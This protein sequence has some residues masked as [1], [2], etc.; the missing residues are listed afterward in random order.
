MDLQDALTLIAAVVFLV[1]AA[2]YVF[3]VLVRDVYRD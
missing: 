2:A 1:T 3:V